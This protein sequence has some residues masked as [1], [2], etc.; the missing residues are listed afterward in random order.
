MKIAIAGNYGANNL[1][2]ELILGGLLTTLR[3]VKPA[4]EITVLSANPKLITEKFEVRSVRKF[5]AG[6]RS[7]ITY[8]FNGNLNKTRKTIKECDFFIL[9]GGGLFDDASLRAVIIWGVQ[10]LA[11]SL[12]KKPI[13]MYGQNLRSLKSRIARY[14]V[15]K[16]FKKAVFI[17][18]RDED[19]KKTIKSLIKGKKIYL[20]PDLIFKLE[21]KFKQARE[22]K[23]L[24]CLR[25]QANLP[26][27]FESAIAGFINQ[28]AQEDEDLKIEFLPF[29][30][31]KDTLFHSKIIEKIANKDRISKVA[32][33]EKRQNIERLFSE[34][35]VVLGMRLHSILMA[36]NT[37]TPFIAINYNPKV[38]NILE[39]LNLGQYLVE[40][41]E[42]TPERLASLL[43]KL[44]I[45]SLEHR[46]EN[47]R[48]S[49][50]KKHLEIEAHLKKPLN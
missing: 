1:G 37:G 38:K 30:K 16:L 45:S 32:Y 25:Q 14:I 35:K 40:P 41:D 29:K 34:S 33:T 15:K 22:N 13:I 49:Q 47:I 17:A 20:M 18:V 50:A 9:G 24:I 48:E 28:L 2:D 10:G 46:L 11:A 5:P 4:A 8:L 31:G 26:K 36:I 7:F 12:H 43:K 21:P 3:A 42:V 44:Q 6:I 39:T 27:T 23:L 19:S